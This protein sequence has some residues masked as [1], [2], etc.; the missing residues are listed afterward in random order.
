MKIVYVKK[1]SGHKERFNRR[2][3]YWSIANALQHAD[4]PEYRALAERFTKETVAYLENVGR[5][6]V[7]T[8]M[9]RQTVIRI[10]KESREPRA[11]NAY[12][13]L[14]FHAIHL[15][16]YRVV[17][18]NGCNEAFHPHKLFKA[19][20][21]SFADAGEKNEKLAEL[22]TREVIE[23]LHKTFAGKPIP[24]QDIRTC[25]TRLLREHGLIRV[26]R[27]YLLHKYL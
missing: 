26:E 25:T 19:I 24:A 5:E 20:K 18:R 15:H 17:K 27:S 12:E 22:L 14:S 7:E 9:I 21:K 11:A 6:F 8:E 2:K 16:P 3:L 10:L 1:N 4:Y 23:R 13:M